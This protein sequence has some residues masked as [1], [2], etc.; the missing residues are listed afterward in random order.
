M[1]AA[2]RESDLYN[3]CAY[4]L[5]RSL[6]PSELSTKRFSPTGARQGRDAF[7]P[8]PTLRQF[9]GHP[10]LEV[11][12]LRREL[13]PLGGESLERRRLGIQLIDELSLLRRQ[14][15]HFPLGLR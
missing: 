7:L 15:G 6:H 3:T 12:A 13:V 8:D 5:R 11:P 9:G 4:P 1:R 10:A 14:T 2:T